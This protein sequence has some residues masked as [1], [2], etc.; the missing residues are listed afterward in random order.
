MRSRIATTTPCG[1]ESARVPGDAEVV[2]AAAPDPALTAHR[3]LGRIARRA[4]I[5]I[6]GIGD[7]RFGLQRKPGEI[8]AQP[9]HAAGRAVDR[10]DL[11]AGEDKLRGLAARG[12]AEI[13]H[14]LAG[15]VAKQARR[16]CR[17]G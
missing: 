7:H 1:A 16:Q 11:R 5:L 8:V 6:G 10:G 3:S 4:V 17:G 12:C 13:G 9:H 2:F 14:R 15:E